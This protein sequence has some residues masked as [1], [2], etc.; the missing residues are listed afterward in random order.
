MVFFV[1]KFIVV[2]VAFYIL[3]I[4]NIYVLNIKQTRMASIVIINASFL[5]CDLYILATIRLT[6]ER[7]ID[8]SAIC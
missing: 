8:K 3:A 1:L 6:T 7:R 5:C 4:Y 2:L